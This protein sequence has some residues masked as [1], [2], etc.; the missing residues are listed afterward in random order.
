MFPENVYFGDTH[1]HTGLSGDAG[2][3]GTTLMPRDAYRFTRGEQVTSNTGQPVKLRM[4]FDFFM[5]TDHS[6]GMGAITDMIAGTPNVIA[7]PEGKKFHEAFSAG[8][9]E[10][11]EAAVELVRQFSQGELSD[12]LNYQPGNPAYKRVW[13]DIIQ[14]AEEFNNPPISPLSSLMNGPRWKRATTYIAT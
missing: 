5:I 10:A 3:G 1:V 14:A 4:P 6:D 11:Q 9:K 2:G 12:A 8:G 13:D 7:D